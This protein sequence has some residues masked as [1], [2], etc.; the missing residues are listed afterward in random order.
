MHL[1]TKKCKALLQFA[2]TEQVST[3]VAAASLQ[4]WERHVLRHGRKVR[5]AC[6]V[7]PGGGVRGATHLGGLTNHSGTSITHWQKAWADAV[8]GLVKGSRKHEKP[9]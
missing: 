6:K 8:L 3:E 4:C 9:S 2:E 1:V 5:P 7:Q